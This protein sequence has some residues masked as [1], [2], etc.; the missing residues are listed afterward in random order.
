V[1]KKMSTNPTITPITSEPATTTDTAKTSEITDMSNLV[2]NLNGKKYDP[3]MFPVVL[4]ENN[5]ILL[6]Y[7]KIYDPKKGTFPKIVSAGKSLLEA[8]GLKKGV[9]ILNVVES[10]DGKIKVDTSVVKNKINWAKI[11]KVAATIGK[12]AMALV[13]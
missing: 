6:D 10:A 3:S 2:F 9:E 5:N 12:F 4:D 1:V 11:G 13:L 7:S 8:L